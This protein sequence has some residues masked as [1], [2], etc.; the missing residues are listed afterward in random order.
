MHNQYKKI[1]TT[2]Q[3]N[4]IPYADENGNLSNWLDND[5]VIQAL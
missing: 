3:A 2:P 5:P 4:T 1:S